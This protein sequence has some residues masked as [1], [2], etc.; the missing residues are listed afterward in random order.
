MN[1]QPYLN[2]FNPQRPEK[3]VN[4]ETIK[5]MLDIDGDGDIDAFDIGVILVIMV[6]GHIIFKPIFKRL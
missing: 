1:E 4:I 3:S 5:E 2:A 6:A